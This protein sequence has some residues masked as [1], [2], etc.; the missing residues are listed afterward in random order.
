[1]TRRARLS[2][3]PFLGVALMV[4]VLTDDR[5]SPD[6]RHSGTLNLSAA[7][8]ILFILVAI[9]MLLRRRRGLNVTIAAAVWLCV[10]SAIALHTNGASTETLREGVRD[11]SVLALGVIVYN[12]RGAVSVPLA[13]RL[14]QV[15]GVVPAVLALYQFASD[16]GVNITGEL[17]SNGTFAHPNSAAM[18]FAIAAT[19]SL[20]CHLD[21]GGRRIDIVLSA[22]FAAALIVTFSLDGLLT[23]IAM[24]VFLG[25]LHP[26]R[27]RAKIAPLVLAGLVAFGYFATPLGGER[28]ARESATSVASAES[29]NANTSLAWR[30]HKWKTLLPQWES[31]PIVG[32]GL[33]TTLTVVPAIG[34]DYSGKPPHN[35]YIRYLVESGVL[36]LAILLGAAGTMLLALW[37]RRGDGAA[38]SLG[39]RDA[40]TLAIVVVGGCLVNSLADNT[41]INSP[42]CYAAALIVVAVLTLPSTGVPQRRGASG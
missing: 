9:V 3:V 22:I 27:S 30:L 17:R 28:I 16:T 18:F 37:R 32:R 34:D 38:S 41:L 36:G 5:S 6:S 31:S 13:A 25:A 14:V 10:W 35:E 42:T 40:A 1:M 15:L 7:I 24:L 26:G 39:S 12:A 2:L 8:A 20:W 21:D 33:G 11:G 29:G 19:V 23:M 4:R